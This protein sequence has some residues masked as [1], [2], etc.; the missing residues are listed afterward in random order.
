MI[1]IH[2]MS[3]KH[4]LDCIAEGF[5]V[6]P[7]KYELKGPTTAIRK[8]YNDFVKMYREDID[9]I[10]KEFC[11]TCDLTEVFQCS[12]FFADDTITSGELLSG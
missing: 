10:E 8:K 12:V 4:V 5:V 2:S 11:E 1:F 9:R 7:S 3:A 6:L